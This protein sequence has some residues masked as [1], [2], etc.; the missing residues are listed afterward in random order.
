MTP[1]QIRANGESPDPMD[2]AILDDF[3]AFISEL[4]GWY[5]NDGAVN[6][7]IR[8]EMPAYFSG[9]KTLDQVVPVLQDRIQTLL[10]ERS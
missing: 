7:I 10:N 3:A 9:Q 1:D 8:E 2:P 6:A 4:T 5:I